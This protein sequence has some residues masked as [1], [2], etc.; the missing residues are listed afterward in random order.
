ML[1]VEGGS[2]SNKRM[3]LTVGVPGWGRSAH[4]GTRPQVMRG[5][6]HTEEDD[7]M[8]VAVRKAARLAGQV[9]PRVRLPSGL[10]AF[11]RNHERRLAVKDPQEAAFSPLRLRLAR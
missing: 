5:V 6:M 8:S 1:A 9:G 2:R 3:H 11:E 4:V 7:S 10:E